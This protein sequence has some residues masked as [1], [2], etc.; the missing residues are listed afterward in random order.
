MQMSALL[1]KL[2]LFVAVILIGMFGAKKKIFKADFNRGL[3]WLVLNVLLVCSIISS[4]IS[5]D[6][7][8]LSAGELGMILLF[9]IACYAVLYL[10]SGVLVRLLPVDR[11]KAPHRTRLPSE[12]SPLC[13]PPVWFL[14]G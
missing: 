14:H 9:D 1:T 3:T 2:A 8:S 5:M 13:R 10:V 11:E 7:S 4:V 12:K 6:A